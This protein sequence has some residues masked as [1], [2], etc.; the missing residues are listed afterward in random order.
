MFCQNFPLSWAICIYSTCRLQKCNKFFCFS[1]VT[2]GHK[3]VKS[4]SF[5]LL[6]YKKRKDKSIINKIQ[7]QRCFS[8]LSSSNLSFM[9]LAVYPFH[10][11]FSFP[12]LSVWDSF[13]S[14]LSN[15]CEQTAVEWVINYTKY[16]G[17]HLHE[18]TLS[19]GVWTRP[20]WLFF[21]IMNKNELK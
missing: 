4:T 18:Y 10:H 9:N 3:V 17:M 20:S 1:D 16:T 19:L 21:L 12:P 11:L 14:Y 7:W 13:Q 6:I 5:S 2:T 15:H 8:L